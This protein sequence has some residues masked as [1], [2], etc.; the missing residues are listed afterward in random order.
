MHAFMA[1]PYRLKRDVAIALAQIACHEEAL[2]QGAPTSPVV[3]NIVSARMDG[4]LEALAHRF[5]CSYT[6]YADDLT[7]ST[8]LPEFPSGLAAVKEK[9]ALVGEPLRSTIERNGFRIN[10]SKVRLQNK[11]VRQVVTGLTVNK[12]VNVPRRVVRQIRAM[13]HAWRKFGLDRAQATYQTSFGIQKARNPLAQPARFENV[14][15]GKLS[16]LAMIRGH[17]DETYRKLRDQYRLALS[18]AQTQPV[19]SDAAISVGEENMAFPAKQPTTYKVIRVIAA[20]PSD[21]MK[22]RRQLDAVVDEVNKTLAHPRGFHLD[23]WKW[24]TDANPGFHADGP[25][26]L[27]DDQ[28]RID[29]AD[30]VIGIFWKKFGTP[31]SD[32]GSGTE[33]EL[34]RAIR[35]WESKRTPVV[36]MYHSRE[37]F[38][39][40][41]SELED[42]QKILALKS[43]LDKTL[44][45]EYLRRDFQRLIRQHLTHYL[46]ECEQTSK[47]GVTTP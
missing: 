33:H 17:A 27:V 14:V 2:P 24:E 7:F 38:S 12:R 43:S 11:G 3:S 9:C 30:I 47:M 45:I 18:G 39:P 22:E 13:L 46:N 25:Q 35:A 10:V 1:P 15:R 41:A 34:R 36:W 20:S 26:G 28:M 5:R 29:D 31:V 42:L 37:K 44:W 6:R 32:A 19:R 4:E 8:N 40:T 16:Y 21:V 23:L